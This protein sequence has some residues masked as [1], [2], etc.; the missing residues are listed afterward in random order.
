MV[1]LKQL[2]T[3][4]AE[5]KA[6]QDA[7]YETKQK[8]DGTHPSGEKLELSEQQTNRQ[9]GILAGINDGNS[10]D[11]MSNDEDIAWVL[12]RDPLVSYGEVDV[13]DERFSGWTDATPDDR[14]KMMEN[15]IEQLEKTNK[16]QS[17]WDV[18]YENEKGE[19]VTEFVTKDDIGDLQ[20]HIA[21]DVK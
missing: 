12:G 17:G 20:Q 11:K 15:A 21:Y 2:S 13:G 5:K 1:E 8:M 19:T 7:V 9:A 14:R 18:T 16:R 4:Y 6:A 3:I 10:A